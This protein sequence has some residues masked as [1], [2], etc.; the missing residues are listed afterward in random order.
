MDKLMK[1]KQ[2]EDEGKNFLESQRF[3]QNKQTPSPSS[4]TAYPTRK[5]KQK[6]KKDCRT[7]LPY[8]EHYSSDNRSIEVCH[9]HSL[10]FIKP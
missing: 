10:S 8:S 1:E 9:D 3:C 4:T 2:C 5:Q 6:K 7:M